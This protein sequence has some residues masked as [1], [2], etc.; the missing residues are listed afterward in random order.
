[1][2]NIKLTIVPSLPYSNGLGEAK[3]VADYDHSFIEMK[4]GA[5]NDDENVS[6]QNN[7]NDDDREQFNC[8]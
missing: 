2:Q 6:G 7:F 8:C 4:I 5:L 1:M 3:G